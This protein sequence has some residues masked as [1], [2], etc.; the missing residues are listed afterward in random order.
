[1]ITK[2]TWREQNE[3]Y[4][5]LSEEI[6]KSLE[7]SGFPYT[8][9]VQKECFPLLLDNKDVAVQAKTGSG[10]T[11]AYL[12]PCIEFINRSKDK[13][14][15]CVL[16][17]VPTRELAKQIYEVANKVFGK[18]DYFKV[19]I[20]IGGSGQKDAERC[21]DKD[22]K[23]LPVERDIEDFKSAKPNMIIATAGRFFEFLD[24]IKP[25]AFRTLECLIIDEAD[26]II[27]NGHYNHLNNILQALPRQRRTGLFSAT[28]T[29]NVDDITKTGMRNPKI[30]IINQNIKLTNYYCLVNDNMKFTQLI[31]FIRKNCIGQKTMLFCLNRQ[32]VDYM[33]TLIKMILSELNER[34]IPL[35]AHKKMTQETRDKNIISFKNLDWGILIATDVAARG[36]DIANINWVIQ[37]DPPQKADTYIHR[38]GRTARIGNEG[39]SIIFLRDHEDAFVDFL[40][41]LDEKIPLTEMEIELPSD[42]YE[43]Y[44]KIRKELSVNESLYNMSK[45]AVV[46]YVQSYQNIAKEYKLLFPIKKLDIVSLSDSFGLIMVPS[47]KEVKEYSKKYKVTPEEFNQKYKDLAK[48]YIKEK[49][50]VPP[51]QQS[52]NAKKNSVDKKKDIPSHI[53]HK[54][55]NN[56]FIRSYHK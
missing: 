18:I 10:K 33:C 39:N 51:I 35:Y 56:T 20:I 16:I 7:E 12:V 14:S 17:L 29:P 44:N 50:Y 30:L 34:I 43:I 36:I 55:K 42:A 3:K 40:L 48:N 24:I 49:V 9:H 13:D 41:L 54:K 21:D 47:M 19:Q 6:I 52:K 5:F 22:I 27:S 31:Q 26:M 11:L 1:M 28:L 32:C 15:I 4:D 53:A 38:I 2:I 25:L 23:S 37:Y 45:Q 8:T 46:S